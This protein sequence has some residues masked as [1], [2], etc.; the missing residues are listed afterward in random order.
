MLT[1]DQQLPAAETDK[2]ASVSGKTILIVL[3]MLG[4]SATENSTTRQFRSKPVL[5]STLRRLKAADLLKT[6]LC[7]DD[8]VADVES[9]ASQHEVKV[10]SQ[11]PRIPLANLEA[12]SAA[13]RWSDGWR[14]GPIGV[15]AFDAGFHPPAFV[16]AAEHASA[17]AVLLVD[18][19]AGLIDPQIAADVAQRWRE[20][21]ELDFT[22][23]PAAPGLG[24]MLI[25]RGLLGR[26]AAAH[27]HPG[28]LLAYFPDQVSREPLGGDG[29]VPVPAVA[30][31]SLHR[32]TLNSQRQID[33][34]STAT[35]TLNGQLAKSGAELLAN[36]LNT[37]EWH[38]A[39]PC[40]VTLELTT[41]RLSKSIFS[42][43]AAGPIDR[44]DLAFDDAIRLIDELSA[45]DESRLTLAGVGDPMLHARLIDII[46]HAAA[47]G[48]AV[49]VETDLLGEDA[50]L[51]EALAA[52]AADIISVHSPAITE[53]TYQQVMG[54]DSYRQVLANLQ[55]LISAR[56]A[57]G[58]GTPLVIPLF[59]KCR[60]NL[61]EMEPWYDQ[62]LRALGTAVMLG[63]TTFA[64]RIGDVAA[65]NMEPPRRVPC[66][67]L[68]NRL[69]VLSDSTYTTCE[70]DVMGRQSLGRIGTNALKNIWRDKMAAVRN[71]HRD[72]RWMEM[73]A[74]RT[75]KEWHRS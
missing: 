37:Q 38:D 53:T 25:T 5:D 75:C 59:T 54:V 32:F 56:A 23:A 4:E 61:A 74:C 46:E 49:N 2:H 62:W 58:R 41:R 35:E 6:V 29:C 34:L 71:C 70:Q 7:W 21:P 24:A 69:T 14:C 28:K 68:S 72:G 43:L 15:S 55:R 31:R 3:S 16:D 51:I 10:I 27:A 44:C 66:R 12:I 63:P 67:R 18:P 39:L 30:A 50:S 13:R 9:I 47:R 20:M 60:Q 22:V 8:Q 64:G 1:I 42:A 52:S 45:L 33:K 57:A 11:G 36:R 26:L 48:V 40:E 73:S 65:A 17:D 19:A